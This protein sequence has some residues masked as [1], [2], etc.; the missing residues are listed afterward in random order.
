M[1]VEGKSGHRYIQQK[2]RHTMHKNKALL[3]LIG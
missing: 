3:V 2:Y 1:K